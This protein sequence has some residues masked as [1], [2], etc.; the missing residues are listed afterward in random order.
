MTVRQLLNSLDSAELTE[1]SMFF[2][3]DKEHYDKRSKGE[4][5]MPVEDKIKTAFRFPGAKVK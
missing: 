3:I 4:V 1:W 2:K 5:D